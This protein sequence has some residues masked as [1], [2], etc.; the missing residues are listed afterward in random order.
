MKTAVFLGAGCSF[1]KET[2]FELIKNYKKYIYWKINCIL[3]N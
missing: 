3:K 2:I 1:G